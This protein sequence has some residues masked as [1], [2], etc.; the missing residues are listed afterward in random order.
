MKRR[1]LQI[2]PYLHGRP[3]TRRRWGPRR[4]PPKKTQP[5]VVCLRRHRVSAGRTQASTA[6]VK[7]ICVI[8]I[9][10]LTLTGEMSEKGGCLESSRL[11]IWSRA[12]LRRRRAIPAR[13]F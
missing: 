1:P 9:T 5:P 10:F 7:G 4:I 13:Y 8:F 2:I 12:R 6:R 11:G 3:T